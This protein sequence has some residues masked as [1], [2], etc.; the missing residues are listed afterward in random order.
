MSRIGKQSIAIPTGTDVSVTLDAIT[1]KGKVG[2]LVKPM[3]PAVKIVIDSGAAQVE[4]A[5]SSRLARALWGTYAAH[6][7]NMIQGVNE[8][9]VKRLQVEGIGF[10]AEV[11]GKN[12]KLMVGF[13]HPVLVPIP[14]GI[15]AAVEKNIIVITGAN[16]E[17]VGQFA[18]SVRE[19][20]KPEPYKGKGI[21]YE[22]EVVRLKQGKKA[23]ATSA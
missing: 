13:S 22:G 8:P 5:N 2:T 12:L 18:A 19:I 23:V 17:S 6:L 9:F 15:A 4:P 21:R 11:A 16:K 14:E 7:K 3:H 20:K 1:V 10:R